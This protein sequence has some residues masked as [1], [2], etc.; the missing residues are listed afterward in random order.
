[1]ESPSN[2]LFSIMPM[3]DLL[4]L[5]VSHRCKH[6]CQVMTMILTITPKHM[7]QTRSSFTSQTL[8]SRSTS[9]R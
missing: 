3:V 9:T 7:L 2:L 4:P 5:F 8:S 6:Q 1:M